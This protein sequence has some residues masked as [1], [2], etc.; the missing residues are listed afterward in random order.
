MVTVLAAE[1]EQDFA[2]SPA[3]EDELLR[4]IEEANS[5]RTISAD[6]MRRRLASRR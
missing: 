3:D 2:L 6:E 5:G 1:A 4:R